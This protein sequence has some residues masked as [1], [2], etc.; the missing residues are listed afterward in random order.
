MAEKEP[1][2]VLNFDNPDVKQVE[3]HG[4]GERVEGAREK[5]IHN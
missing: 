1:P 3:Q 4:K 5:T 2:L